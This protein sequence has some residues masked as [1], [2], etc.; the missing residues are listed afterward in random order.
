[1]ENSVKKNK[2]SNIII[3]ILLI[4]VGIAALFAP[5]LFKDIIN[6]F[7]GVTLIFVGVSFLFLGILSLYGKVSLI[8]CGI[9]IIIGGSIMFTNPDAMLKVVGIVLGVFTL[10]SAIYKLALLPILKARG[11]KIWIFQLIVGILYIILGISLICYI[12]DVQI[13]LIYFLG[14]Y[15]IILGVSRFIDSFET[16]KVDYTEVIHFTNKNNKS[17]ASNDKFKNHDEV[18]DAN[19]SEKEDNKD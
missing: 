18:V 8:I 11:G 10:M 2:V 13:V 12:N 7:I 17:K 14:A 19:Y 4:L 1:M 6:I 9:L 3:S 5:L 15:L 16:E